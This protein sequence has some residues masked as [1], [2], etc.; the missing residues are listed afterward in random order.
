MT[1]F[2]QNAFSAV[3]IVKKTRFF[4]TFFVKKIIFTRANTKKKVGNLW[5]KKDDLEN[6]VKNKD[7]FVKKKKEIPTFFFVICSCKNDFFYKKKC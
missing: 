2:P 3:Q 5:E 4:N 1:R 7:N 6:S